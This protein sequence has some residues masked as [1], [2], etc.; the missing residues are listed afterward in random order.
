MTKKKEAKYKITV[1]LHGENK[2]TGADRTYQVSDEVVINSD[3]RFCTS[4]KPSYRQPEFMATMTG[5]AT[6]GVSIY[7][8]RCS[9]VN[10]RLT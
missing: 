1:T 4:T 3:M 9:A 7:L 10:S 2:W 6:K 5:L 8:E